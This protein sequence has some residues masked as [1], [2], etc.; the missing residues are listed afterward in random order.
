MLYNFSIKHYEV[1]EINKRILY[2]YDCFDESK[3]LEYQ[4]LDTGEIID[5]LKWK[6][7]VLDGLVLPSLPKYF[8][9]P[10]DCALTL[11]LEGS[12]NSVDT[13]EEIEFSRYI[14]E[15]VR[16]N[17]SVICMSECSDIFLM[18]SH[19]SNCHTGY[20]IE[21]TFEET[22]G[23]YQLLKPVN[24]SI[25]RT[26]ISQTTSINDKKIIELLLEK[27]KCWEYEKEWRIVFPNNIAQNYKSIK[28]TSIDFK[29]YISAIY[30]GSK[31]SEE[32]KKIVIDAYTNTSIPVYQ[33]KLDDYEYKL[34]SE[35]ILN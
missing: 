9:D 7:N 28:R 23:M 21:Y 13:S 3:K 4:D 5:K 19:Y 30:L 33:M 18:W 11:N 35:K 25:K 17:F 24:Y 31:C 27:S 1:I 22:N 29:E 8:N 26:V 20:C 12:N 10:Y 2:K 6:V 15:Y 32:H 16:S 14:Q 34:L